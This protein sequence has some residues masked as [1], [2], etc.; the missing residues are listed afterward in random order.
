VRPALYIAAGI[1]GAIQHRVGME[2]ADC[3]IAINNDPGAP[4]FD[5]AHYA[6]V[7]DCVQVLP[8][9]QKTFAAYLGKTLGTP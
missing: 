3:I 5:F 4:I 7:G 6:I 2:A 8:A 9:L 1:S